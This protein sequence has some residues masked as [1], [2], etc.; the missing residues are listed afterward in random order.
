M[1]TNILQNNAVDPELSNAPDHKVGHVQ[2]C[3]ASGTICLNRMRVFLG[4]SCF[5][6]VCWTTGS[7]MPVLASHATPACRPD[8]C[9]KMQQT[10]HRGSNVIQQACAGQAPHEGLAESSDPSIYLLSHVAAQK[11]SGLL[12]SCCEYKKTLDFGN[13]PQ[14]HYCLR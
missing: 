14:L 12:V 9:K 3:P 7:C 6:R 11:R 8:R 1:T 5:L 10:P 13:F 4:C 2:G